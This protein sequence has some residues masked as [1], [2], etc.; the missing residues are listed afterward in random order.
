MPNTAQPVAVSFCANWCGPCTMFRLTV[1]GPQN[2]TETGS[3]W[4]T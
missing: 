4:R 1:R 3:R 2:S